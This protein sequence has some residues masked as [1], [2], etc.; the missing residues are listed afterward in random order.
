TDIPF[1]FFHDE[2]VSA[3]KDARDGALGNV[4][5]TVSDTFDGAKR[6]L[7]KGLKSFD[8]RA[9][10]AFTDIEITPDGVVVRGEIGSAARRAPIVQIAETDNGSA[11]TALPSWIPGGRIDRFIWSWTEHPGDKLKIWSGVTKTVK[12]ERHRFILPKPAGV[13]ELSSVCLRIE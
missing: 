5:D 11:F 13:T 10:A 6:Q 9:S 8:D 3:I 2:F 1:D 4:N 12:D 7:V